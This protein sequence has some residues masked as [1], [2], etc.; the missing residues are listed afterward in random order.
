M[1]HQVPCANC[2]AT[3][4]GQTG[5]QFSYQLRDHCQA[6]ESGDCV[7]SALA[8]YAL[9]YHHTV[10]WDQER[11]LDATPHLQQRLTL[12]LVYIRSQYNP[13]NRDLG[14]MPQVYNP[15]FN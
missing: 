7:N 10:D 5:R 14:T 9:G 4:V 11:V 1:V 13:V 8:D 2:P 12:E 6:V 3:Y 15:L